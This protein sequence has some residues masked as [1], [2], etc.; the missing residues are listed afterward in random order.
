MSNFGVFVGE[1]FFSLSN[2]HT[3]EVFGGGEGL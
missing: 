2:G 1:E 3:S